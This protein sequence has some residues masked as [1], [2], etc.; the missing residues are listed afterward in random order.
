MNRSFDPDSVGFLLADV[1]R[2]IRA[3]MDKGTS[4]AGL[5]L[6]PGD[7]RT[8]THA[9][10]AGA[11]RQ[12]T[13]ADRMGVEAMTL[14]VSLDRLEAA[15]LMQRTADPADRRAKRVRLTDAGQAMLTK[16]QPI[17]AGIREQAAHGIDPAD[18]SCLLATLKQVR[19][20]LSAA[21]ESARRESAAA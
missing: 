6:T 13:L 10:R 8:L 3:E 4:E 5:G 2:L 1:T 17:A 16:I 20:N 7:A 9:A 21:R 11:I 15:G 14:S 19:A 18:W 12:T